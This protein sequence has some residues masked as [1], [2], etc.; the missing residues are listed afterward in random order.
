MKFTIR[1]A[2]NYKGLTQKEIAKRM[3]ISTKTYQNYE[4]GVSAMRIDTAKL[5]CKITGVSMDNIIF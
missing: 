2:R 3:G 5:F 4:A 1:T